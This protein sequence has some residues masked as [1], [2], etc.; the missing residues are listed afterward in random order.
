MIY[1]LLA[2]YISLTDLNV[3][4]KNKC[5][6]NSQKNKSA[7]LWLEIVQK[8]RKKDTIVNETLLDAYKL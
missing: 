2:N 5:V 1:V 7:K 8:W 6:K 3:H 4:A